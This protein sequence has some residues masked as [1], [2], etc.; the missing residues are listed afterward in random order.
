MHT[1]A[2]CADVSALQVPAAHD[3]HT[4]L[5]VT[6]PLAVNVPAGQIA[7]VVMD[8]AAI[9]AE[10]IPSAQS[11]QALFPVP[12]VAAYFPTGQEEQTKLPALSL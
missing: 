2:V 12:V 6:A 9:E 7:Q 4:L 5:P 1:S 8:V 10:N 3:V 11:L